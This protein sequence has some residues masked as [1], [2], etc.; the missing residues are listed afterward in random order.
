MVAA[1]GPGVGKAAST[2]IEKTTTT[3]GKSASKE[4]I[5]KFDAA[6]AKPDTAATA[7]GQAGAATA[8]AT[9]AQAAAPAKVGAPAGASA[10]HKAASPGDK[11][12]RGIDDMRSSA[13]E[14]VGGAQAPGNAPVTAAGNVGD[15]LDV[16]KSLIGF[17]I[18]TQVGGKGVQETNQGVQTLLKGQ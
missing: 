6:M 14:L 4:Q 1:P 12:L 18:E 11:I 2:A 15:V 10:P 7:A 16:Q 5:Q 9:Q 13:K 17:E 8:N 3:V